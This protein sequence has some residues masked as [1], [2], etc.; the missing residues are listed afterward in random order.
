MKY[1]FLSSEDSTTIYSSNKGSNFIVDLPEPLELHGEW[2]CALSEIYITK[3]KG[4]KK[5]NYY[6]YCDIIDYSYINN[7]YFPLLRIVSES[8]TFT[9]LYY[10]KVK[11][12]TVKQITISIKKKTGDYSNIINSLCVLTLKQ[13]VG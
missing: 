3:N 8:S 7:N 12:Q 4:V 10:F 11:Q 6:I 13:N 1:L 9:N 2:Y 5:Q